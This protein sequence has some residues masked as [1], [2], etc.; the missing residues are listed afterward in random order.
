MP[1]YP[2]AKEEK[3]ILG[4][5]IAAGVSENPAVYPPSEFDEQPLSLAIVNAIAKTTTRQKIEA[6]LALAVEEENAAVDLVETESKV[7]LRKAETKYPGDGA[8]LQLL[9]WDAR[10]DPKFL[11]PGQAR[12]LVVTEQ[13]P[14]EAGLKWKAPV[15]TAS[16]GKVRVYRIERHIHDFEKDKT[17]EDWGEW[18]ATTFVTEAELTGQ[19]RGVEISYRVVAVNNNGDGPHS[20]AETVVL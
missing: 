7:L 9:G 3:L 11:A 16:V 8:K 14:G 10:A 2:D 6:Q 17:I 1:E 19:P 12:N 15:H 5:R 4:G 20:D 13:G 18:T